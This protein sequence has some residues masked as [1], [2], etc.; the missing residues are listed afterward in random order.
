MHDFPVFMFGF[1]ILYKSCVEVVFGMSVENFAS[2]LLKTWSAHD[3]GM[4][5]WKLRLDEENRFSAHRRDLGMSFALS[6]RMS[7]DGDGPKLFVP[8]G[9]VENNC[10]SFHDLLA[11][12]YTFS[13][14]CQILNIFPRPP[15]CFSESSIHVP[16]ISTCFAIFASPC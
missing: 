3:I 14:C 11:I 1:M 9:G 16:N 8:L 6:C 4:T 13:T 2:E 12:V 7:V 15:K 5:S 10:M